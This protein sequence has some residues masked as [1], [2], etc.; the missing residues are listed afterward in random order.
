MS[1]EIRNIPS[2]KLEVRSADGKR[3]LYGV[4]A[5]FDSLSQLL[6]GPGENFRETIQPGA[7]SKSLRSNPDVRLSADHDLSVSKIL[8][9]TSAGT[10]NLREGST[11]L[12]LEASLPATRFADDIL[13]SINRGDVDGLSISFSTDEDSWENSSTGVVRTLRAVTLGPEISIVA[14]PAYRQTS[15]NLRSCPADIA[16]L[17]SG[18]VDNSRHARL[19]LAMRRLRG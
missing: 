14:S 6:G 10:M 1:I 5:P 2:G 16:S 15:I 3:T 7:F 13:E 9:R 8:A 17:L 19:Q 12:E 4:A 11:G 18:D